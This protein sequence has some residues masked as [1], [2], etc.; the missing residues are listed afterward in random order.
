ML[1][2]L[3][4]L[5]QF[6]IHKGTLKYCD[7]LPVLAWR[8]GL[9]GVMKANQEEGSWTEEV[10][11]RDMSSQLCTLSQ[12]PLCY[13]HAGLSKGSWHEQPCVLDLIYECFTTLQA[14]CCSSRHPCKVGQPIAWQL[15]AVCLG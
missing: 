4:W 8:N 13:Q 2:A 1:V 10:L 11:P 7:P 3:V 12:L 9:V 15:P 5:V 6:V 14:G